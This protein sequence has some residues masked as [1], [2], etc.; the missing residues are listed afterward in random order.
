MKIKINK[1]YIYLYYLLI[2]FF[3]SCNES[4]K[5]INLGNNIYYIP[6]QEII[7]D[8]TTFGGNGIYL[9]KNN[10]KVPV[11][12][13]DIEK[14]KYNSDFIIVKQNFNNEQSARLVDNMLFL[15]KTY[16][17]YDKNY[18]NL[19]ETY[20]AKLDKLEQNGI[21]SEKFTSEI[22]LHTTVIQK[23]K[24]NKENFY[25]IEKKELKFYGPLT[26]SEFKKIKQHLKINLSFE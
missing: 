18:I 21:Y 19:N 10:E 20:L 17:T 6:F 2:F 9:Y 25:I 3:V 1:K 7:F 22:L 4:E 13:P 5:E 15:P 23:M 24:R 11:I 26:I 12:L 16:F 14:Y 8:V